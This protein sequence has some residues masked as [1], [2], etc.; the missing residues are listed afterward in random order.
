[1]SRWCNYTSENCFLSRANLKEHE[2]I[3]QRACL[4]RLSHEEVKTLRTRVCARHRLGIYRHRYIKQLKHLLSHGR[5]DHVMTFDAGRWSFVPWIMLQY[6]FSII[7][8]EILFSL[9]TFRIYICKFANC[10]MWM[11][12]SLLPVFSPCSQLRLSSACYIYYRV[13]CSSGYHDSGWE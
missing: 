4:D 1:M 7:I 5:V 13:S 9:S 8:A 10:R 6:N 3:P 12:E 2:I 11:A